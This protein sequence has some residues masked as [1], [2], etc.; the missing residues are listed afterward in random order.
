M[1]VLGEPNFPRGCDE[2]SGYCCQM[3]GVGG[4]AA[5]ASKTC[6]RYCHGQKFNG[7]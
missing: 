2:E 6:V 4:P 5:I 1:G 3:G 7:D